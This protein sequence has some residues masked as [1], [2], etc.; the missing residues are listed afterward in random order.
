[1]GGKVQTPF[2]HG[3]QAYAVA[4]QEDGR[5]VAAG[6]RPGTG[7][8]RGYLH[9][10][11]ARYTPAGH[12]D[13]SFGSRGKVRSDFGLLSDSA[14]ALAI[15]NDGAIVAAGSACV[16]YGAEGVKC[17]F[18]LARYAHDGQLDRSFGRN[19]RVLTGFGS[20]S[21]AV[22]AIALQ[23]DGKILVGGRGDADA[24]ALVR[25]KPD[26]R[27]DP[28]FG[29]GG[30]IL[31]EFRVLKDGVALQ[32]DGRIVV[33]GASASRFVLARYTPDGHVDQSFG[34]D[35]RIM[36]DFGRRTVVDAYAGA[37]AFQSDGRIVVAGAASS[38][39]LLA[40][41]TPDGG[42]D[43]SFGGNGSVMTTLGEV[44]EARAVAIQK[45]G[46]V[47]AA[48]YAVRGGSDSFALARYTP[49]GQLDE[50]FGSSGKLLTSFGEDAD[51][52]A[53]AI[54]G[55][56]KIVV[57]GW[58][59]P[60]GRQSFALVRYTRRGRLDLGQL[61]EHA[62][63]HADA[64]ILYAEAAARWQEFGNVP[65]RAHAHLGQGRCLLALNRA[66]AEQPL[67]E[68][69]DLFAA[70]GYKPAFAETEALLEQV[71]AAPAS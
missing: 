38:R 57:A 71:A 25:Y 41:Y 7:S 65:E 13:R 28:V 62:G 27:L 46:K 29:R 64:A 44:P 31:T 1:V 37:A 4:I 2:G 14:Q 30:K 52:S 22:S 3:A 43:R 21:L 9:F 55:D 39:F 50:S 47:V 10:A 34:R 58:S 59:A 33:A 69:R 35:G 70:M 12:L 20:A 48:G 49:G 63:D 8:R 15:Q 60:H 26:G 5:I 53:I 36:A 19:G 6:E 16:G 45:D 67:R 66:E 23:D 54:Q 56:G 32:A 24:G 17:G 11:L 51:A 40:R 61:A 42:V 68:A 18:A